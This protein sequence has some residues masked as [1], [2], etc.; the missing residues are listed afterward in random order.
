MIEPSQVQAKID[1]L[2]RE[3]REHNYRYYILDDPLISDAE[4]DRLMRELLELEAQFPA[5]I[6]PDSPT[7]RV[8]S[9]PQTEFGTLEHRT[10]MLSLANA[11]NVGELVDFDQRVRKIL[12]VD[13]VEYVAEPKL[14][15]LGVELIYEDG[16]FIA[17]AT[18][19][20][21]FTGENIT[22]NLKTI[23]GLPLRLRASEKPIPKLLEVRGEVFLRHADFQ[24][25]N[26]NRES[27]NESLFANPRNA[28]AGSLR[29]LDSRITAQRPL[30]INLYASGVIENYALRSHW[31]F[32]QTLPRWGF[33]VN[34]Q[35]RICHG[36]RE[37]IQ[38]YREMELDRETLP[39]DIDGIVV[40]VND[41]AAQEELGIR[42]R[43]PRWAIAGK[44]KARQETT[45]IESIEA[46]VGRT[47]AITPVANLKPVQLG[48]VVVARATLHNQ[49]E[50][51]RKDVRVGDTVLIQR[52]GD[53][54]PEVVK[55]ILEKRPAGTETYRIPVVCPVCGGDVIRLEDE[56][57]HYC[58]NISCSAQVVGRIEHF[59]SKNA[60]DIDGMG[61]K[62]IEQLVAKN[63]I[64][65]VAD[66]YFLSKDALAGLE[67]MA[68]KSAEN[69][70]TAIDASRTRE[71]WRF[72]N[73]LGIRNV[74]EHASKLLAN[75][76]HSFEALAQAS[77]EALLE[78]HEIGPIAA[79][80]ITAFFREPHNHELLEKLTAGRV[81]PEAP[82]QSIV[83]DD[84]FVGKTFVFTGK[85]E[86]FSRESAQTMV[87][88]RG[89]KTAGSVSQ[90]TDYVVA[91]PGAGS[92]LVN[93][94]ALGV[95]VLSE[96]AFLAMLD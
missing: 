78:I 33:P 69:I 32:I 89:G 23:Q 27:Q 66:L 86:Q 40:K 30:Q 6:R 63:L 3:L 83:T 16:V 57:K 95:Q 47:G 61:P 44:F 90:K 8:G 76:F 13:S 42:S 48:G 38:Y 75:H 26:A 37:A 74:G 79:S 22:A 19:G 52:A 65:T 51:D 55:V 91:G 39:Y 77:T 93:A 80:A 36:I 71:L 67:R 82:P 60:M 53:V 96:D 54:I 4:Y 31:E 45:I 88:S 11:M 70:L 29:Q 68:D 94:T 85:L 20:D 49:D 5:L 9:A 87:E 41:L 17:G 25:L 21:G 62:L 73:A 59:A 72:I 2:S 24:K 1:R 81:R 15:G 14:D 92:K 56:A 43:S 84:R 50:V 46:S 28:A 10:P 34:D 64:R 18:R 35:I 58:Q 7:M 12:A